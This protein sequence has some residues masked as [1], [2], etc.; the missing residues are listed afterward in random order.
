MCI[1]GKCVKLP[2]AHRKGAEGQLVS[3]QRFIRELAEF[4]VKDI[5]DAYAR[6]M[7]APAQPKVW[8]IPTTL[9]SKH[10]F[11]DFLEFAPHHCGCM[12]RI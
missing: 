11:G 9:I 10:V 8:D 7:N 5:R 1:R 3:N 6:N 12:R 2:E 4:F